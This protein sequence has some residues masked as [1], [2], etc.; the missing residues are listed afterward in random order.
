VI[1][2]ATSVA[3]A[4]LA[5]WDLAHDSA[6]GAAFHSAIPAHARLETY[7]ALARMPAP[8]RLEP[9]TVSALLGRWFPASATLVPSKRLSR[10]AV[11]RCSAAGVD[12]GAVYD[13]LVGLTAAEAKVQLLTRDE[14]AHRTYN[15]LGIDYRLLH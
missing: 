6:R 10:D 3:V 9:D 1:A 15:R 11:E 4:A 14:R 7:S 13:A 12:G 2:I 8:H 5:G